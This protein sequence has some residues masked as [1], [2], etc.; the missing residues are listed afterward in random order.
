M[1]TQ[2]TGSIKILPF[3]RVHENL[4]KKNMTLFMKA[5]NPLYVEILQNGPLRTSPD[6]GQKSN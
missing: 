3:D 4:W 6:W 2:N 5:S 1:S